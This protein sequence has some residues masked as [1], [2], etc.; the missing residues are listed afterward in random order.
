MLPPGPGAPEEPVRALLQPGSAPGKYR[1]VLL[2]L[3][4]QELLGAGGG[5]WV[6]GTLG[7]WRRIK[8]KN[9]KKKNIK[10]EGKNRRRVAIRG[11]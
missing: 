7:R 10:E 3:E 9:I 1:S 8:K 2:E 11:L 6:G 4:L 5:G